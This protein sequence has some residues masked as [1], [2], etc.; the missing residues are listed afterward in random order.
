MWDNFKYTLL[1]IVRNPALLFWPLGFP[2]ILSTLF[3]FMFANLDESY[4]IQPVALGVVQDEAYDN[5]FGLDDTLHSF[6]GS[7]DEHFFDLTY[8]ETTDEAETAANG[9]TIEGY[10]V[11]IDD[12]P[13]LRIP[14]SGLTEEKKLSLTTVTM[15]LNGYV[16]V[17]HEIKTVIEEDPSLLLDESAQAMVAELVSAGTQPTD[18][19]IEAIV[20]YAMAQDTPEL[21]GRFQDDVVRTERLKLTKTEPDTSARY[22][23]ALL[24]MAAGLGMSI[25]FE[26]VSALMAQKSPLG[27]RRT[28][29]GMPRWRVLVSSL[30]ASWL[31]AFACLVV[32]MTFMRFAVGVN[33][34]D[35]VLPCVA[36]L[37]LSSLVFCAM[38]SLF[39][40]FNMHSGVGVAL[41]TV[42]SFFAGL[43]GTASQRIADGIAAVY[44]GLASLNPVRQ[45]A[46]LFYSLLYYDSLDP[47]LHICAVLAGMAAVFAAAAALRMRRQRYAH[48]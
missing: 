8:F 3:S 31:A 38:G 12:K 6:D 34:G 7:S 18:E 16:R 10:V 35:H 40:T 17:W 28:L 21:I 44:P 27:A 4:R 46:Q 22:Y 25:A 11:V 30:G 5:A 20:Q 26:V 23:Y 42:L 36:A 37:A 48:L 9:G 39:A 14:V 32:G 1:S 2:I 45:T 41:T 24:G 19:Q 33:F 47:Y 29:A 15:V 43:Y 13:M